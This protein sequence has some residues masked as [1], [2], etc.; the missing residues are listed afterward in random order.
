M[1][2]SLRPKT[3]FEPFMNYENFKRVYLD[4]D[5]CVSWDVD[6]KID[7]H[8]VWSNKVDISSDSCYLDS[9]RID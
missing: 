4:E 8:T 2:P 1:K 3:V 9:V 5:L 6:P 7:S